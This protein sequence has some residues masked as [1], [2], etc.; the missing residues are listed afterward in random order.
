MSCQW[1]TIVTTQ[2]TDIFQDGFTQPA[3]PLGSHMP[4]G[5]SSSHLGDT[6]YVHTCI[7]CICLFWGLSPKLMYFANV[8]CT[9]QNTYTSLTNG[10][11]MD[12]TD[13]LMNVCSLHNNQIDIVGT[14]RHFSVCMFVYVHVYEECVYVYSKCH[15]HFLSVQLLLYVQG[16]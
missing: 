9:S 6:H 12:I 13:V 14:L 2:G 10:L 5:S 7:L 1:E 11:V 4:C 15:L 16:I 3:L 8:V